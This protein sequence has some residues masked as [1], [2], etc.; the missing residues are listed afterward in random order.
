[1]SETIPKKLPK[2]VALK[3]EKIEVT[4]GQAYLW[5]ACGL[6]QKQP[7]CDGSHIGTDFLPVQYTA[8]KDGIVGFCLCKHSKKSD[9]VLCDG[10]HKTLTM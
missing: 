4:A 6:S 3:S 8:E 2:I 5:C 1:M 7:F 10:A 9:G